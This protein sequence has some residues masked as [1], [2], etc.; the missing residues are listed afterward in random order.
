MGGTQYIADQIG[1]TPSRASF[2]PDSAPSLAKMG[3][4]AGWRPSLSAANMKKLVAPRGNYT[5]E[6]I[7]D[8]TVERVIKEV[9]DLG[10]CLGRMPSDRDLRRIGRRP[11]ARR[12]YKLGGF[13]CVAKMCGLECRARAPPIYVP[14]TN[15]VIDLNNQKQVE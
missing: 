11:L 12:I 4:L 10:K 2:R 1:L 13:Q 8:W 6:S 15:R 3:S 5:Q 14:G 7:R 9:K